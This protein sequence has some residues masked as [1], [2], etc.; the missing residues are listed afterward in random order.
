VHKTQLSVLEINII[1]VNSSVHKYL[2]KLN[3]IIT[4]H[5][6]FIESAGDL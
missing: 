1:T 5:K 3:L 6:M 4:K 2:A